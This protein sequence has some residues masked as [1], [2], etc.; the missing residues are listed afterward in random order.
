MELDLSWKGGKAVSAVFRPAET[1][2]WRVRPPRGQ[3]IAGIRSPTAAAALKPRTDGSVEV[4][5]ARGTEYRATF[6]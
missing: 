4:T 3:K 5:L 2:T 1:A 6:G